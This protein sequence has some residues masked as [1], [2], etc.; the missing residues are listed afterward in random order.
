MFF[1]P[2]RNDRDDAAAAELHG[3][4][5]GPLHAIEFEDAE[6]Q[7][8]GKRWCGLEFLEEG[9]VDAVAVDGCD[10]GEPR[11]AAGD[12][13]KFHAWLGAQH[14][15]EMLRLIAMQCG[16]GVVPGI[17]DPAAARHAA[18]LSCLRD[19]ISRRKNTSGDACLRPPSLLPCLG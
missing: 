15:A 2:L 6:K 14:A 7:R 10:A 11:A 3:F 16:S 1:R 12:H 18:T 13:V 17:C 5:N 19:E 9:E 4:L 8:D